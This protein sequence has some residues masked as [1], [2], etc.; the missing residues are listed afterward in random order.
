MARRILALEW[1]LAE[2]RVA[3]AAVAKESVSLEK[4]LTI[5]RPTDSPEDER[6]SWPEYL[7]K[8][9]AEHK[10]TKM[11][12]VLA[13]SRSQAELKTLSVPPVPEEELPEIV[14][15]Q[16]MREFHSLNDEWLLDFYSLPPHADGQCQVLTAIVPPK[17]AKPIRQL[18]QQAGLKPIKL[19]LRPLAT[20][21][22]WQEHE[23]IDAGKNTLLIDVLAEEVD[24][25]M[26]VG[27]QPIFLRNA[28]MPGEKVLADPSE[29]RPLIGELRRTIAAVQNQPEGPTVEQ[30]VLSGCSPNCQQ[31][32]EKL[33]DALQLPVEALKPSQT[34]LL[35][36]FDWQES[37]VSAARATGLL[38][39]LLDEANEQ[40]PLIDF[41]NPKR[42]P[43][44]KSQKRPMILAA[45]AALL[46]VAAGGG[47][48]WNEISTLE[49]DIAA[50]KRELA[51]IQSKAA[52]WQK[53]IDEVDKIDAWTSEEMIW[54][55]ELLALSQ[56]MP[57]SK[58]ALLRRIMLMSQSDG[59]KISL[60]GLLS[61]S[62][63]LGPLANALRDEQHEVVID[64]NGDVDS[65]S[66]YQYRFDVTLKV[67]PLD[68]VKRMEM[69]YTLE[70]P[71]T[72]S[73]DETDPEKVAQS[74]TPDEATGG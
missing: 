18:C 47:W 26:I 29:A 23:G 72:E 58:K 7:A 57:D 64:D 53:I 17:V 3:V 10:L 59:G 11:E 52:H 60:E 4:L 65:R 46:L 45:V 39:M 40:A 41:W 12:T 74:Q 34:A 43:E 24:L 5:A 28:R 62:Q 20:A 1:D 27:G 16:A 37:G 9:L 61:G 19:H 48:L 31:L 50:K 21:R 63:E 22:T 15:F 68:E 51:S 56:E 35:R 32:A 67:A 73:A 36:P 71:S 2:A 6:F 55:D 33:S 30:L 49:A 25:V 44:P 66:R 70:T 69:L 54:L 38:G 8:K 14:R 42:K 13:V